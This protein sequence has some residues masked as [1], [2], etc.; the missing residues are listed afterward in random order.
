M[1]RVWGR[2]YLERHWRVMATGLGGVV[3]GAVLTSSL[4]YK[5]APHVALAKLTEE[6]V[7]VAEELP[8]LWASLTGDSIK[9]RNREFLKQ[10]ET[11]AWLEEAK[12]DYN[13]GKYKS[14]YSTWRPL[15][16]GGSSSSQYYLGELYRLGRGVDQDI[17]ES[18]KWYRQ[19]AEQGHVDAQLRLG[20]IY[21]KGV[22][23]ECLRRGL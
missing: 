9:E 15:A 1:A 14:A 21:Q 6:L 5:S 18:I 12:Q 8:E 10:P 11:K 13:S 17:N 23:I 19:A 16:A 3:L 22:P 2:L 20:L 4:I 7:L